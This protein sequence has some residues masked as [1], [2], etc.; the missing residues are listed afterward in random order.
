[1]LFRSRDRER[2]ER[3]GEG[4]RKVGEREAVQGGGTE[5][6]NTRC[7]A[8]FGGVRAGPIGWPRYGS[9][10]SLASNSAASVAK[11]G[12]RRA[13]R[14]GGLLSWVLLGCGGGQTPPL[15][16]PTGVCVFVYVPG[17]G[18]VMEVQLKGEQ[19]VCDSCHPV[20]GQ[21]DPADETRPY[22]EEW[23]AF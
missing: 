3:R 21:L 5:L 9:S 13:F 1:M 14:P 6:I 18:S 8:D 23:P 10:S 4:G 15:G 20:R 11:L 2:E 19:A 7:C 16:R 22:S 12:R 17:L